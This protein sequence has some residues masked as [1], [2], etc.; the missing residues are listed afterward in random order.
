ML[1][2]AFFG[3]AIFAAIRVNVFCTPAAV[4]A[5]A[6]EKIALGES[7]YANEIL[8]RRG[9]V[10]TKRLLWRIFLQLMSVVLFRC[11]HNRN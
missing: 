4:P 3:G 5:G 10:P 8:V 1:L 7:E 11:D 2:Y 6:V 9:R